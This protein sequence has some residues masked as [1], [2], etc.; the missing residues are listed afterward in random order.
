MFG[1]DSSTTSRMLSNV[2]IALRNNLKRKYNIQSK[3][4]EDELLKI[5]GLHKDNFDFIKNIGEI[6]NERLKIAS[7]SSFPVY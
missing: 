4:I 3:E 5:H 7:K 2:R 1:D 6:I